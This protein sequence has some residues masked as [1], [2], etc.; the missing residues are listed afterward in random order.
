MAVVYSRVEQTCANHASEEVLEFIHNVTLLAEHIPGKWNMAADTSC[1]GSL[2]LFCQQLPVAER[3][4]TPI[5][6]S[7][8]EGLTEKQPDCTG[9]VCFAILHHVQHTYK[10]GKDRYIAFCNS[11]GFN[12]LL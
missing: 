12:P 3:E 8:R 9:E 5:P 2:S 4:P 11:T 1:R 6:H 7:L 10:S